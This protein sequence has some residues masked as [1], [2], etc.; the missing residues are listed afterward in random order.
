MKAIIVVDVLDCFCKRGNLYSERLARVV[1]PIRA[2][3]ERE[4]TEGSRAVFLADSHAVDDPEFE[5]FPPHCVAGSGEEQIVEEL[6]DIA[7]RSVVVRKTT[8]SAFYGTEL[9]RILAEMAPDEID[10]VGVCTDIC[11]LHTVAE[12]RLRRYPVTVHRD[13]VATYDGAGHP[14][15][16]TEDFALRHMHDILGAR[17]R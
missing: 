14:A 5:M 6:Q 3:L 1:D 13:L 11:V 10:V 12:L 17:V 4:L 9:D 16:D 7:A 8:Y 15:A 2:Y